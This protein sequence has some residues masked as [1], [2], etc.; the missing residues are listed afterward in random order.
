[1]KVTFRPKEKG[2]QEFTASLS[3]LDRQMSMN[4]AFTLYTRN[5]SSSVQAFL[6]FNFILDSINYLRCI[7]QVH[8]TSTARPDRQ[9]GIK[10]VAEYWYQR[11]RL[12]D[13]HW[14][15]IGGEVKIRN[16][17]DDLVDHFNKLSSDFLAL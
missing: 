10:W 3:I 8:L 17:G 16:I 9:V 13:V 12:V 1:M 11:T 14:L 7:R 4:P 15:K 6:N 5:A 2:Y